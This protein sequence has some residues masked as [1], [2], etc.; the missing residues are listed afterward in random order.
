MRIGYPKKRSMNTVMHCGS[1][2]RLA[3]KKLPNEGN[4]IQS[5]DVGAVEQSLVSGRSGGWRHGQRVPERRTHHAYATVGGDGVR[6]SLP[7]G[8]NCGGARKGCP[9]IKAL[10]GRRC[11]REHYARKPNV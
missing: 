5:G 11:P 3:A 8:S 10:E 6:R 1:T 7:C 4:E 2:N 9:W